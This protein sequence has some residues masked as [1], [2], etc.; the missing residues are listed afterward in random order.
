MRDI[1]SIHIIGAG[2]MGLSAGIKLLE[3][4]YQVTQLAECFS[5]NT[6]SDTAPACF[7]P[8]I[9]PDPLLFKCISQS[10]KEYCEL[11]TI[12]PTIIKDIPFIELHPEIITDEIYGYDS[13]KFLENL[14]DFRQLKEDE[15]PEGYQQGYSYKTLLIDI[16]LYLPYLNEKFLRLGG[17]Q[18]KK[19]IHSLN[20]FIDKTDLVINCSGIGAK[21]LVNDTDLTAVRG[22]AHTLSPLADLKS[23]TLAIIKDSSGY[24]EH[25]D[26][27]LIVPR[28]N[29]I[30]IA[31]TTQVND[32]E[33]QPREKDQ[34]MIFDRCAKIVPA[35]KQS[36]VTNS[37]VGFRPEMLLK[38]GMR[39][40]KLYYEFFNNQLHVIHNYGHA[41][42]GISAAPGSAQEVYSMIKKL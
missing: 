26:Y 24:P 22:Q 6:T 40:L 1:K 12:I 29:N 25:P 27:A 8:Y 31:G 14:K 3:A 10:W 32:L 34:T 9:N 41:G 37:Y 19:K 38:N 39:S 18:E 5:P 4:G 21:A 28:S 16:T 30:Y 33:M 17:I 2:I 42:A 7:H 35:I 20:E 13:K 15:L 36:K 11:K 23:A